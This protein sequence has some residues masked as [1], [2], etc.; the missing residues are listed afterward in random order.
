MGVV[1]SDVLKFLVGL[2]SGVIFTALI[3]V[4]AIF[5][6]A[7]SFGR[8]RE[9]PVTVANGSTL[10]LRLEGDI[11][12]RP[13]VDYNIPLFGNKTALTVQNV[14]SILR[15]AAADSRDQGNGAGAARPEIGWGKLQEIRAD[16]EQFRKSGQADLRLPEGA[17]H[18]RLLPGHGLRP[19]FTCQPEDLLNLKGH[20]VR[21]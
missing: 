20:A 17:G 3:A 15:K 2:I 10:V 14:W 4:I 11:P 8:N 13:P 21:D 7:Y 1:L 6:I 18:A 9:K 12:E 5:A 19:A 16:I